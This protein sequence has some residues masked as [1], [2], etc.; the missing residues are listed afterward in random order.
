MTCAV[1]P[2]GLARKVLDLLG[3]TEGE[4]IDLSKLA[5]GS[6]RLKKVES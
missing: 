6:V 2:V 5:D 4:S 1:S 3:V